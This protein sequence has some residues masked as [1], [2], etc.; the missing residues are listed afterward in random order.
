M[1]FE[2]LVKGYAFNPFDAISLAIYAR[3]D[4]F[5]TQHTNLVTELREAESKILKLAQEL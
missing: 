2:N 4:S 5:Y 1:Y 3:G